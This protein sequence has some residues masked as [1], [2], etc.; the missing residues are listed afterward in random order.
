MTY[1]VRHY[2]TAA[3]VDPFAEWLN[4]LRDR[5]ARARVEARIDRVE[6]GLFGDCE[7]VGE[8]VS[9]LRIDWGPGYR[10]YFGRAGARIVLLLLGCDKRKQQ[11]DIT[12]AKEYWHDYQERT[13]TQGKRPS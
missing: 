2:L 11:A 13:K 7:P 10:V 9:E 1:E 6:R 3:G 8:G 5:Q 12:Q 4:A